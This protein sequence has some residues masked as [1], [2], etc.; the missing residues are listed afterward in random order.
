MKDYKRLTFRADGGIGLHCK[1]CKYDRMTC[2]RRGEHEKC[3]F[4][5]KE[6]L[7]E[8]EDEIERGELIPKHYIIEDCGFYCVCEVET[9]SL[10]VLN[11]YETEEEA[12]TKLKEIKEECKS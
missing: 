9:T 2:M 12:E 4:A 11:Q 10:I 7:A 6:R 1:S 8:L 5:T 3:G